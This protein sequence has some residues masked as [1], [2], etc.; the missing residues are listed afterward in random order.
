MAYKDAGRRVRVLMAHCCALLLAAVGK[1]GPGWAV[2]RDLAPESTKAPGCRRVPL[3]SPSNS[4]LVA[5]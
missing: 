3:L 5:C 4:A 2:E 1:G